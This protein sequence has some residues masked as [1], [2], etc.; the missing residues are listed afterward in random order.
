MGSKKLKG[1]AVRGSHPIAVA[2]HDEMMAIGSELF[3]VCFGSPA[4]ELWQSYGTSSVTNWANR[5]G[6]FP[7]R[8]FQSGQFSEFAKLTGIEMRDRIVVN[9]KGCYACPIACGKY[10]KTKVRDHERDLEVLVEGPEYETTALIGGNCALSS[11]EDVA[12]ANYLCDEY[13][14]DTI[15]GGSIVGF[16]MECFER[17]ILT[18]KDTDGLELRFGNAQAAFDLIRMIASKQGIGAVLA[19]GTRA[20]ARAFGQGSE[21]F[22]MQVKGLEISGYESRNLPAMALSYMTSDIGAHHRASWAVSHDLAVGREVTRGKAPRVIELQH[23][24]TMFDTLGVCRL[25]WIELGVP[26][27]GYARAYRAITGIEHSAERLLEISERI[28]NLTRAFNLRE[29]P[30]YGRAYDLPPARWWEEPVADGPTQGKKLARDDIEAM[31]DEYYELRGWSGQGI[32]TLAR[33]QRLGLGREAAE[34]GAR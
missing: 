8:N 21:K 16:A 27:A 6:G 30:G 20:A 31:L 29:T 23:T 9:D 11:I 28:W 26:F 33:M 4:L 5:I 3:G 18:T 1:I 14:I 10:S 32:P 17:G 7:T 15:S 12:Y 25:P 22:A 34:I 13:G 19:G 24:R 2:R